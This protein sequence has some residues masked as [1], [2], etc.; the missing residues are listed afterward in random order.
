MWA[1]L[2]E[3]SCFMVEPPKY[4][5][6]TRKTSSALEPYLLAYD[7]DEDIHQ[8]KDLQEEVVEH[9]SDWSSCS[10]DEDVSI[11][12]TRVIWINKTSSL[13]FRWLETGRSGVMLIQV[14]L[15]ITY[16]LNMSP[17]LLPIHKMLLR[18]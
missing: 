7:S 11:S 4:P 2:E 15:V 6:R 17:I 12:K 3:V 18:Y 13:E 8:D 5:K 1:S 9:F 10:E 16:P 14:Y